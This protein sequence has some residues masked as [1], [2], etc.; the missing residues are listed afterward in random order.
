MIVMKSFC[1]LALAAGLLPGATLQSVK[2]VYVFPMRNAFD[3]Y[4]VAQ[5]AREHVFQVVTDPKTADAVLTDSM[6]PSFEWTFDHRVLDAKTKA[7]ESAPHTSFSRG[8]GTLFLVGRSK[9][10]LWSD[11]RTP[12]DNTSKQLEKTAR[13][14]VDQLKKD[15][16]PQPVTPPAVQ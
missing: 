8:K 11:Y 4:L 2:T 6:G 5:I 16:S 3:Q 7:D 15:L 10:V 13:R 1:L 12:K 14:S 9:E